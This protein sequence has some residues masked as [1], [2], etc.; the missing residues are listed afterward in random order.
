MLKQGH[1]FCR[2]CYNK[3]RNEKMKNEKKKM[4]QAV[5]DTNATDV[6]LNI[7]SKALNRQVQKEVEPVIFKVFQ[8]YAVFCEFLRHKNMFRSHMRP[9]L[10]NL[11]RRTMIRTMGV[12]NS[13][14]LEASKRGLLTTFQ[15]EN[16]AEKHRKNVTLV[17]KPNH[18]RR[19]RH[20]AGYGVKGPLL[21]KYKQVKDE[22]LQKLGIQSY[23]FLDVSYTNISPQINANQNGTK[24]WKRQGLGAMSNLVQMLVDHLKLLYTHNY[25]IKSSIETWK[26]KPLPIF[27][28]L[29]G[30]GSKLSKT[31]ENFSSN[32]LSFCVQIQ[33]DDKIFYGD[34]GV[35]VICSLLPW[36]LIS[37]KEDK[38]SVRKIGKWLAYGSKLLKDV[39]NVFWTDYG[40][41]TT[42]DCEEL[43]NQTGKK[44]SV[45]RP[46]HF[47]FS[48]VKGDSKFLQILT[49]TTMSNS[50]ERCYQCSHKQSEWFKVNEI[51]E[52]CGTKFLENYFNV[53]SKKYG[54]ELS[55]QEPANHVQALSPILFP[56]NGSL[57]EAEYLLSNSGL[58]ST[59]FAVDPLHIIEN[60][61]SQVFRYCLKKMSQAENKKLEQYIRINFDTRMK[62]SFTV[63]K[64]R[65]IWA[66]F[67]Q[68]FEKIID[69]SKKELIEII[70]PWAWC[71]KLM[72]LPVTVRNCA[73]WF[74][75]F[76]ICLY[77]F[78]LWRKTEGVKPLLGIHLLWPHAVEQSWW[79]AMLRRMRIH[80]KR[81]DQI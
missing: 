79:I 39:K 64:W 81:S 45:K 27:L 36:L 50:D 71:V 60:H 35:S 49:G 44:T 7:R 41:Q 74:R 58:W 38:E 76:S 34:H 29:S 43:E 40:P 42:N 78:T 33:F 32:F 25:I 56:E 17:Q 6:D 47:G 20:V 28:S 14:L 21:A 10:R 69:G 57:E 16:M 5:N 8:N 23:N 53:A 54:L 13:R 22:T 3:Q 75:Y 30:D 62:P 2:T 48:L 19:Q 77:H 68:S 31:G 4:V 18:V 9:V 51:E 12:L 63:A 73:N 24:R 80:G 11:R 67:S 72:Y 65:L 37:A 55:A 61:S 66:S 26:D 52:S 46:I 1:S 70:W 59:F 15:S